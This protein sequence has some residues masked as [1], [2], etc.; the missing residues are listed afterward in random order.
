[1]I[2]RKNPYREIL[3]G[4]EAQCSDISKKIIKCEFGEITVLFIRQLTDMELLFNQIVKPIM[5]Q[6]GS[7]DRLNADIIACRIVSTEI[8]IYKMDRNVIVENL[9]N[10]MTVILLSWDKNFL[11]A[12]IRSVAKKSIDSPE[13]FYT[14]RGPKDCFTEN[15]DINLS[16]IRYRMK[17]PELK[18]NLLRVG[19]RTK[20]RVAVVYINDIANETIVNDVLQRINAIDTDG[21]IAS[22]ELQSFLQN[23]RSVFFPQVGLVE[24]SDMACTGLLEGKIVII[25]EGS[26]I[27]LIAPKTLAEFLWSCDDDYDHKYLAAFIK[28]LRAFALVFSFTLGSLYI[29][30]TSFHPDILPADYILTLAK[31][32]ANVPLNAFTTIF[33]LEIVVEILR[34]A[35][36]R[37]PRQIGPAIGI[38]GAIIIGQAAISSHVFDPLSLIIVSLSFLAS[39]AMPDYTIM[40]PFRLLKFFLMI[41]TATLGLFGFTIGF[42]VIITSIV[43]VNSFGV[44]YTA[45]YAPYHRH[46]ALKSIFYSKNSASTRPAFLRTKDHTRG[47][48]RK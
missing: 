38:A 23:R 30:L 29:A 41:A 35:L 22:G 11:S 3:S 34:E 20:S 12:N 32:R 21:I 43:S 36:L 1:M 27:A 2:I 9:M 7:V 48:G 39:F 18:I 15:L 28:V 8:S 17:D 10:G 19:R 14:I 33:L 44:A 25:A 26:G 47:N 45:P 5:T 46:D 13:L 31:L 6:A 37:V 24:R 4:V 42:C 16:L 40:N